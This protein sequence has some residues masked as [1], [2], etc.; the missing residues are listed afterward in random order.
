MMDDPNVSE[1]QLIRVSSQ[2]ELPF[3]AEIAYDAYSDLPRQPSWSSWLD[4]VVMS[5]DG[6]GESRWTMKFLGIKYS[7]T[8][9]AVRNERPHTIQWRSVTGL[10][11]YGTVRFNNV[12][13]G[14]SLG[15]SRGG[16]S[17]LMT[18]NMTFVAP[19]A[20]SAVFRKSRALANFVEKRMIKESLHGFR[21]VVLEVDLSM[22][23]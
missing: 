18:M 10:R 11:N 23:K 12:H 5:G 19:R 16:S 4:T 21:D 22:E 15:G 9:V 8:A 7:W 1:D 6:L 14:G 2:V 13:G 20:A 17:T 3:S